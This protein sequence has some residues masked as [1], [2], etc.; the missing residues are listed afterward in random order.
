V[1][2]KVCILI[3]DCDGKFE[4]P[5]SSGMMCCYKHGASE[6]TIE[7]TRIRAHSDRSIKVARNLSYAFCSTWLEVHM[8]GMS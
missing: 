1:H 2:W 5:K 3:G 4:K 7:T 6:V 8:R